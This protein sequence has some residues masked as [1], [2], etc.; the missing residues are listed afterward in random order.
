[1]KTSNLQVGAECEQYREV[2]GKHRQKIQRFP[3]PV[4]MDVGYRTNWPGW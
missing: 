4:G 2:K 3:D 1:M